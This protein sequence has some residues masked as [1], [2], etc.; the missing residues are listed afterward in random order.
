[1]LLK[2]YT[3]YVS[4]FGKLSRGHKI[5]E[6]QFSFQSKGRAMT[7]NAQTTIQLCSFHMLARL[8][9]KSFKLGFSSMWTEIFHMYQFRSVTQSCPTF[10]D[11]MDC[12]T[13]GFP[14]LH[15]LVE[16]AQTH[17]HQ[18][19]DAIQPSHPLSSPSSPAFNLFQHQGLFKWVRFS[20][21]VDKV[22]EFHI[23]HQSFQ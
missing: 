12:C 2:C 1:M 3:Q 8:C 22:L 5:G 14:I 4:K 19:D 18:V 20:H 21:Q 6:H 11:P 7:K 23:Q 15:Q 16:L 17:I 9:S 13:P 10:C